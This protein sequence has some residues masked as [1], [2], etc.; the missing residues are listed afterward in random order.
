MTISTENVYRFSKYKVQAV[1]VGQTMEY[2]GCQNVET[3]A[4]ASAVLVCDVDDR[5]VLV[6]RGIKLPIEEIDRAVLL[7]LSL[8]RYSNDLV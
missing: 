5:I 3:D 8:S 4:F 7:T 1:Y 2:I 6:A